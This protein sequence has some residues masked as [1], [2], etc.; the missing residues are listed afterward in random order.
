MITEYIDELLEAIDYSDEERVYDLV[1]EIEYY[2]REDKD[3]LVN[4]DRECFD[5]L[6]DAKKVFTTDEDMAATFTQMALDVYTL[7]PK[8]GF[9]FNK[10]EEKEKFEA[11]ER[12]RA[13]YRKDFTDIEQVQ[14]ELGNK[15]A[16]RAFLGFLESEHQRRFHETA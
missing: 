6:Q 2:L 1:D 15:R 10:V 14:F 3:V 8:S 16:I 7:R 9:V 11:I 5:L 13:Q 12:Y 4:K